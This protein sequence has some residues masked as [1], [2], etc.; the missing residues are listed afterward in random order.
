MIAIIFE[1]WPHPDHKSEYL[2][3]A[4]ALKAELEQVEGFISVERFES[5]TPPAKMMSLSFFD[6][7]A[8][9]ERWRLRTADRKAQGAGGG[10]G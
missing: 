10:G 5:L 3:I 6:D 7:D 2:G 4:A 9:V 8:A 1:V